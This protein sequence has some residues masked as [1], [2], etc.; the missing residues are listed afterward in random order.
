MKRRKFLGN[1]TMAGMALMASPYSEILAN[2]K[3]RGTPYMRLDSHI[4]LYDGG[5]N[6]DLI[7]Q[8]FGWAGLTHGLVIVRTKDLH[9]MPQLKTISPGFV[10]FEW[11]LNPLKLKVDASVPVL[12]Y[13]IHLRKP[14]Q[15]NDKGAII[16]AA[17]KELDPVCSAAE[18]LGRPFLFHSDADDPQICNMPQM[19]ELAQRHPGTAFI[20]AHTAAYTQEFESGI[21]IPPGEW[22]AKLPG[23]LKQNFEMLLDIDNLYADTVLLGRDYP[24]RGDDPLYKLK[25]MMEQ[26][27][28]MNTATKRKLVSKLFIGTDFPWNYKKDDPDSGYMYQVK[29]MKEIFGSDFN[30]TVTTKNFIAILPEHV[31]SKYLKIY[32]YA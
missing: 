17:S 14:M 12:G 26:V 24:E 19:A 22:Q 20:A 28:K 3:S 8:Y 13:K 4:H 16:N 9:L 1:A 10:P 18:R 21:S 23:I 31:R 6:I 32:K 2:S 27:G 11:P 29:C 5:G 15:K 25:L 7:R 30:E